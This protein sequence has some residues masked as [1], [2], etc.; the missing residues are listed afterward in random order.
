[1]NKIQ[2]TTPLVE[3]DGDEMTRILWKPQT[4]LFIMLFGGIF[5]S[6]SDEEDVRI[7]SIQKEIVG[8][9]KLVEWPGVDLNLR[10][11]IS[12]YEFKNNF[13]VEYTEMSDG[14]SHYFGGTYSCE[15]GWRQTDGQLEG[16][17]TIKNSEREF[18]YH[19]WLQGDKM[20]LADKESGKEPHIISSFRTFKRTK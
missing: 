18:V 5:L 13:T 4:L 7:S 17:M 15:K 16:Y 8:R 3:M 6:C 12:F 19:C 9:W 11:I 1:M 14:Y 2:M 10:N 20:I